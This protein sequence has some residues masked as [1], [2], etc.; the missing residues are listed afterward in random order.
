M[1]FSVA[2]TPTRDWL[3]C[4]AEATLYVDS[5]RGSLRPSLCLEAVR[6]VVAPVREAAAA[7]PALSQLVRTPHH[8]VQLWKG[9]L[10]CLSGM[11]SCT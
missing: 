1:L 5:P 7:Y 2:L 11:P 6:W 8:R 10:L 9:P 3:L 4:A